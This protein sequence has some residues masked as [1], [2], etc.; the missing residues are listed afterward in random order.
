MY[1][2][3]PLPYFLS[4]SNVFNYNLNLLVLI[5]NLV[6]DVKS[7]LLELQSDTKCEW[8]KRLYI[9][10]TRF[11]FNVLNIQCNIFHLLNTSYYI[12]I[13]SRPF[14]DSFW[15]SQMYILLQGSTLSFLAGCPKSHLLG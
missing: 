9:K 5:L 8:F 11:T 6:P 15:G 2:A 7:L 3:W 13:L 12:K 10:L 1:F 14:M 4:N